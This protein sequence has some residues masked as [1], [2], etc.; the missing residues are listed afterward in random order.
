[1]FEFI[2]VSNKKSNHTKTKMK[3]SNYFTKSCCVLFFMNFILAIFWSYKLSFVFRKV[4]IIHQNTPR[5]HKIFMFLVFKTT[6][7]NHKILGNWVY[8]KPTTLHEKFHDHLFWVSFAYPGIE[9]KKASQH[10]WNMS[11]SAVLLDQ[12]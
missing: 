1:M 11:Y 7:Q 4:L 2:Y 10:R 9:E 12:R 6:C 8:Q 3:F 5:G